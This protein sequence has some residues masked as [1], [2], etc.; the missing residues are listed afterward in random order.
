MEDLHAVVGLSPIL[1]PF[2]MPS[3]NEATHSL[4]GCWARACCQAM[5]LRGVEIPWV[6]TEG[7]ISPGGVLPAPVACRRQNCL[8]I[9]GI[10][11]D[12]VDFG[13]VDAARGYINRVRAF[14]SEDID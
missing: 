6:V 4:C 2:C 14:M 1:N 13:R 8:A 11:T 9:I 12:D 10:I 3:N 5:G 7:G